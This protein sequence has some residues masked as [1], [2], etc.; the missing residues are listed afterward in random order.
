MHSWPREQPKQRLGEFDGMAWH[1]MQNLAF[2]KQEIFDGRQWKIRL[3][4]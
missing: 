2:L 1:G 3:E 4:M